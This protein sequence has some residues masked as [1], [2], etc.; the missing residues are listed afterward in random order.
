MPLIDFTPSNA[1]Q[2]YSSNGE[3]LGSERVNTANLS[4]GKSTLFPII[5]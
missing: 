1:K 4:K 2:F 5:M 3:P